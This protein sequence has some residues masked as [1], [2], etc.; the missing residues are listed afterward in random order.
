MH[1]TFNKRQRDRFADK[2]MDWGNLV[3]VG[4]AL[5]QVF[6][7]IPLALLRMLLAFVALGT[8]YAVAFVLTKGGER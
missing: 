2:I 3:F 6:E 5:S 1:S 8:A 7:D 4:L